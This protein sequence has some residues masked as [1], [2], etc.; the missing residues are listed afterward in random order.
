MN[1][2]QVLATGLIIAGVFVGLPRQVA[3]GMGQ[4]SVF[5]YFVPV[6][7]LYIQSQET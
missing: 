1:H 5:I 6:V 7:H 4:G 3:A 2:A